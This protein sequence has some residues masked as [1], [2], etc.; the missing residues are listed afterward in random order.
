MHHYSASSSAELVHELE[1]SQYASAF[2]PEWNH[3]PL[4]GESMYDYYDFDT[5]PYGFPDFQ[6][7]FQK[8]ADEMIGQG[9]IDADNPKM[10]L[11]GDICERQ[12]S[13][14]ICPICYWW[15]AIDRAVLPA[16]RYQFWLINLA[17]TATLIDFDVGDVSTPID[18]IRRY[19]CQRYD[20]R[21]SLHPRLYEQTIAS[22]F[23]DIGYDA[24]AT[25]YSNDG[26]IDVVFRG[27][28]GKRIGVQVK[29]R[30]RSVEVE[31]IRSF[32]GAL[33]LGGYTRGIFV[34]TSKFQRGAIRAAESA[35]Q[36]RMPIELVDADRFLDMLGIA[37][38]ANMPEPESCGF[39]DTPKPPVF[40]HSAYHLS[41]L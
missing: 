3:C 11:R 16:V 20:A 35:S 8:I 32:F 10:R 9:M 40:L 4:C 23:R 37:Q 39:F 5:W 27:T 13:I 19:L 36:K 24:E 15:S 28:K 38:L 26:G 6:K 25:A 7:K 29:R 30:R 31:Q 33:I 2:E 41:S 12:R 21:H 34:S 18:E 14:Q 22:V 1:M 17:S